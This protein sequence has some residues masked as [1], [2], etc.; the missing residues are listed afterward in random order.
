M[1]YYMR[2]LGTNPVEVPID[3]LK[4]CASPAVIESDDPTDSWDHLLLKHPSGQEIAVIERSPVVEDEVGAEEIEEFLAD[5]T[6][7]RPA[8]AVKWLQN[9]L[10]SVKVIYA[11]QLL[12]GTDVDDGWTRMHAVYDAIREAVGGITQADGEGFS[13]EDGFTI[14]WQ[15]SDRASGSWDVGVLVEGAW[16][17]AEIDLGNQQHREAF[18]NGIIPANAKIL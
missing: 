12:S 14:L 7:C 8:S 9:Y 13:N 1:G 2:I 17:H 4:Q 6:S 15:F 10:L 16:K 3:Y 18:W 11:F 5:I